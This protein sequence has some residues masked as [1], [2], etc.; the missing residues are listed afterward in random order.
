MAQSRSTVGASVVRVVLFWW[1]VTLLWVSFSDTKLMFMLQGVRDSAIWLDSHVPLWLA[2]AFPWNNAHDVAVLQSRQVVPLTLHAAEHNHGVVSAAEVLGVLLRDWSLW[3]ALVLAA[4]VGS[5]LA[6]GAMLAASRIRKQGAHGRVKK[7]TWLGVMCSVGPLEQPAWVQRKR[8]PFAFADAKLATWVQAFD[9]AHAEHAPALHAILDTIAAHDAFAGEGHDKLAQHTEHVLALAVKGLDPKTG[10]PLIAL[11]AASHDLG[12][13]ITHAKG[14]RADNSMGYHDTLG[15]RILASLPEVQALPFDD[16]DLL[17]LL[18][19]FAHKAAERPEPHNASPELKSRMLY[20]RE[21]MHQADA[22]A[23][24]Q[25][26]QAHRESADFEQVI[27][28]AFLR[29]LKLDA[30]RGKARCVH[31]HDRRNSQGLVYLRVSETKFSKLLEQTFGDNLAAAGGDYRRVREG[32]MA[33][34]SKTLMQW[35][36]RKGWLV[37]SLYGVPSQ[38]GLYDVVAGEL[39]MNGVYFIELKP[40]LEDLFKRR[41]LLAYTQD[42]RVYPLVYVQDHHLKFKDLPDGRLAPPFIGCE[43]GSEGSRDVQAA[44]RIEMLR[45]ASLRSMPDGSDEDQLVGKP[46]PAKPAGG[47][48]TG[49]A[50]GPAADKPQVEADVALDFVSLVDSNLQKAAL[51]RAISRNLKAKRPGLPP[52]QHKGIVAD[53]LKDILAARA[54][55]EALAKDDGKPPIIIESAPK[56]AALTKKVV[57]KTDKTGRPAGGAFLT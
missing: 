28:D 48:A 7:D 9:A 5:G 24:A 50:D 37:S 26:Q 29:A 10:E 17:L 41:S 1:V 45:E 39:A 8:Q 27:E 54:Q 46:I 53:K 11:L 30:T 49:A 15:M 2:K 40:E 16:R 21:A 14:V 42:N 38:F 32:G 56:A 6:V 19:G 43:P 25:E 57:P 55:R 33:G 35:L 18:T 3:I 36:S 52:L 4:V 44:K 22:M 47:G 51:V 20:V 31:V 23:T 12:K 13:V 34:V